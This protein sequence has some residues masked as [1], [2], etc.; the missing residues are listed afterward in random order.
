M[1]VR[2]SLPLAFVRICSLQFA[3][4]RV[5]SLLFV[6]SASIRRIF[7]RVQVYSK[8]RK[9]K[10]LKCIIVIAIFRC[11]ENLE[12]ERAENIEQAQKI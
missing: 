12:K 9:N 6:F 11:A 8:L 5:Y 1:F 10:H 7:C 3:F 4:A 2:F